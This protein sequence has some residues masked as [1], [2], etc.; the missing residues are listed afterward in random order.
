MIRRLGFVQVDSVSA[1]ER[2]QHHILFSRNSRYRT[3][4]LRRLLER[5]RRLFEGWTHDAAILPIESYPYWKHYFERVKKF[6]VHPGYRRYFAAAT[7]SEVSRVLRRIEKEGPLRPRDFDTKKVDWKSDFPMPTVA[8]ITMEFLWRTGKLAVTRRDGREKVYDL[9]DRV[10][11]L[12]HL[13]KEVSKEEYVDWICRESLNRL[14]VATPSQVA[15]FFDGVSKEEASSWCRRHLDQDVLEVRS[16]HADGSV[17]G[18]AFA[19]APLIDSL[20][21]IAE[22]PRSLRLLNPFDPLIHDRQ[23]TRRVFGFDYSLEI[24]VPPKKRK[25]GYYVL[26]IFE[27]ERFTGRTNVKVDR[28]KARL[29]VL[30]LWWEAGVRPTKT[31]KAQLRRELRKLAKFTRAS[32]VV[33]AGKGQGDGSLNLGS[34][35]GE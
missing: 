22:P 1:V 4:D 28:K 32:E 3:K 11:P 35:G 12:F 2:A 7:P 25:Y 16:F 10:I 24:W 9:T 13:E 14:G 33:L 23:R 15:H 6:E 8:K 29:N 5:D 18:P 34:S 20:R 31:R 26:P 30:G 19:P 27:G 17:S 21:D